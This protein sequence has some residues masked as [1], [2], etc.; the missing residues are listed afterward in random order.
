MERRYNPWFCVSLWLLAQALESVPLGVAY[1]VWT[2]IGTSGTATVG[3]LFFQERITLLR[4]VCIAGIV[5]TIIG[6]R[7]T[8]RN[9]DAIGL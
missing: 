7:L 6:L 3:I 2:G 8:V 4:I 1:A 9:R 5:G